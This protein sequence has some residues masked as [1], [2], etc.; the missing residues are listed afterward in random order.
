[1]VRAA[2]ASFEAWVRGDYDVLRAA[3]DPEIEVRLA[4]IS[5]TNGFE[6]PVGLDEIYRGPDGYCESMALWAQSFKNWR[7]E[8]DEVIEEAPDRILI[9]ARHSGEG[10]AS[11][12]KLEQWGAVRYTV[13]NGRVVRADGVLRAQQ[14]GRRRGTGVDAATAEVLRTCRSVIDRAAGRLRAA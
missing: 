12:V 9:I 6:V 11:G 7:A 14:E 1:M 10:I 4:Q 8:L 13:R 2:R 3:A 5:G